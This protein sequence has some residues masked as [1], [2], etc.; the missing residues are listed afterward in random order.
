[1]T[2]AAQQDPIVIVGQAHTPM[3]GF[4]GELASIKATELGATAIRAAVARA[5]LGRATSMRSLWA[6][7]CRPAWVRRPRDR[8]H[9]AR[10][11]P[12]PPAPQRSIRCAALVCKAICS[13]DLLLAQQRHGGGCRRYGKHEQRTASAAVRARVIVSAMQS[14]RS[15][16]L[17]W[18]RRRLR[19]RC[20]GRIRRN[21]RGQMAALTAKLKMP[22]PLAR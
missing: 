16:G 20:N 18:A 8:P 7:C 4:L 19:R 2:T 22:T 9:W 11:S 10:A 21:L 17:R 13:L 12:S 3:G 15:H 6:V 1:M 14:N 5:G